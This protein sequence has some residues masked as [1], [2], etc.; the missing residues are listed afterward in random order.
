MQVAT[1]FIAELSRLDMADLMVSVF[2]SEV[3]ARNINEAGV[4]ISVF[5]KFHVIDSFGLFALNPRFSRHFKAFDIVFTVF[6]PAYFILQRE[7]YLTGFAQPWIIYPENEIYRHLPPLEKI[8]TRLKYW[9]QKW[10]FGRSKKLVVEL[11]HVRSKLVG[12]K[13]AEFDDVF[14]VHNCLSQLYFEE[15]RWMPIEFHRNQKIFTI[16]FVGRDYPHKN[17]AILLYIKNLLLEKY[18]MQVDFFVTFDAVEWADKPTVFRDAINNVGTLTVAQCPTFYKQMDAIIFPSLLECFS[19]TP[20]EAM[21]MKKPLFASDRGF[22]RDICGDFALYF[23][24]VKPES[25][26]DAIAKYVS[27]Q[28]C[29]DHDRLHAA[30]NHVVNFSN[31]KQRARDYLQIIRKLLAEN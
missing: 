9:I 21:A 20:L 8:K 27:N 18:Q 1:S 4:D 6:G 10:F 2:A 26:A 11:D 31:A 14:V 15:E 19:A 23:D 5:S 30:R 13:I 25:A 17:T 29:K 3:V 24:P 7:I 22:V 28:F 12:A 16:G